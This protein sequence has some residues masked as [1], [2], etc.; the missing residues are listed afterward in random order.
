MSALVSVG[1]N[2]ELLENSAQRNP[3]IKG[4]RVQLRVKVKNPALP[5][6]MRAALTQGGRTLSETWSYQ[7]PPNPVAPLAPPGPV[8]AEP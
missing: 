1:D 7:L 6:E 3:A 8:K 2:A 4:V 5:V